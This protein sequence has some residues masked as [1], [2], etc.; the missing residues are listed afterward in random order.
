MKCKYQDVI[1]G[2]LSVST[3]CPVS[4]PSGG[5]GAVSQGQTPTDDTD[6]V[7]QTSA[8][9]FRAPRL[10]HDEGSDPGGCPEDHREAANSDKAAGETGQLSAEQRHKWK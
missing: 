2:M 10:D 4:R 8:F 1:K 9:V 7:C 5:W 3:N 6:I